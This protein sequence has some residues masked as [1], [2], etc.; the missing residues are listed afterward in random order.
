MWIKI[1]WVQ[2][3]RLNKRQTSKGKCFLFSINLVNTHI[4]RHH[5]FV[6][7]L[8]LLIFS[9]S[10]TNIGY[11]VYLGWQL[12]F[13]KGEGCVVVDYCWQHNA[14]TD[15][16]IRDKKVTKVLQQKPTLCYLYCGTI[17]Y[18]TEIP[19]TKEK[20]EKRKKN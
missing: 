8:N 5:L 1:S 11:T 2:W 6:V 17:K 10:K 3:S 7:A 14:K 12:R 4:T 18:E 16:K 15:I 20:K 13:V 9:H 19:C